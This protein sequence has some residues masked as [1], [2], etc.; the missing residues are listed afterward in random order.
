[1]YPKKLELPQ[2]SH[3]PEEGKGAS[4]AGGR[5]S[6]QFSLV[7]L[8]FQRDYICDN[9]GWEGP[10][11]DQNC[12]NTPPVI[13]FK[14]ESCIMTEARCV[15]HRWTSS[16]FSKWPQWI[17]LVS[18]LFTIV[19]LLRVARAPIRTLRTSLWQV[20]LWS[21]HIPSG[22]SATPTPAH[23]HGTSLLGNGPPTMGFPLPVQ[24]RELKSWHSPQPKSDGVLQEAPS[25]LVVL[26]GL[27]CFQNF[28][29]AHSK[30]SLC[31]AG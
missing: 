25:A 5:N 11:L 4:P 21:A 9:D 17:N 22:L 1:M 28:P 14:S 2:E 20:L 18:L 24:R 30:F 13:L 26:M 23:L 27:Y 29:M 8:P 15:S 10:P 12:L 6:I 16:L 7:R 31:A 3:T 19:C